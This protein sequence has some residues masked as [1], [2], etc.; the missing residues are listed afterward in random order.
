M[1]KHSS[2]QSHPKGPIHPAWGLAYRSTRDGPG[3]HPRAIIP[4]PASPGTPRTACALGRQICCGTGN[5]LGNG[6]TDGKQGPADAL[7][8]RLLALQSC[9]AGRSQKLKPKPTQKP[10]KQKKNKPPP[11]PPPRPLDS[12]LDFATDWRFPHQ[13]P[14]TSSKSCLAWWASTLHGR[15][16]TGHC[17]G[18]VP[19]MVGCGKGLQCKQAMRQPSVGS[20]RG[21]KPVRIPRMAAPGGPESVAAGSP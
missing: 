17:M 21:P 6:A 3:T 11:P 12:D 9:L 2:H 15:G 10:Q 14:C 13:I 18:V 5:S 7:A 4:G 20:R 1:P 8:L 19:S 16:N